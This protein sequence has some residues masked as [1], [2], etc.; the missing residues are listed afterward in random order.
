MKKTVFFLVLALIVP[1]AAWPA[2]YVVCDPYPASGVQP[3][4]FAVSVDGG[5]VVES[6]AQA[7]T[8]GV[9]LYYDV[10]TVNSGTHTMRVKAYKLDAVWGRLESTEAVFTFSRPASPSAPAGIGLVK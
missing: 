2:P 8:G 10:S 7:V 5:A 4:G 1:C 3:D 6:P 9:R